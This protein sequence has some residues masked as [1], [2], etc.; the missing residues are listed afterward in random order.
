MDGG[1]GWRVEAVGWWCRLEAGCGVVCA[2]FDEL[3]KVNP[4]VL[5]LEREVVARE[6]RVLQQ[7]LVRPA[8]QRGTRVLVSLWDSLMLGR[9][10]CKR[11]LEYLSRYGVR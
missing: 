10:L 5:A 4:R 11:V 1:A 2:R 8:I 3:D 7:R 9:V 6:L